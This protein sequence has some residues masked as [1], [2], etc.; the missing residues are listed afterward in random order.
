LFFFTLKKVAGTPYPRVPSQK[1]PGNTTLHLKA[2]TKYSYWYWS[3]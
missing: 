2:V 3:L 1:S